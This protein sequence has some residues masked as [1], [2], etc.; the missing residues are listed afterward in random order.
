MIRAYNEMYLNTVA[1]NLAALFDIA[2]NAEGLAPEAFAKQF[3]ASG[4]AKGIEAG[5]PNALAGMSATEMLMLILHK[6]VV[7]TVVPVDRTPEYWAGWVLAIAQWYLNK[8]FA[9]ILAAMPFETLVDMYYPYHEA[10]AYPL[11]RVFSKML[12]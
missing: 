1:H 6:D 9:Q 3:A 4:I 10:D 11:T 5:M 12:G 8:P 2:I 7:Y